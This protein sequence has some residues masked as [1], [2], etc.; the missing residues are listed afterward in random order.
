[1]D[2]GLVH[3]LALKIIIILIVQLSYFPR[4]AIATELPNIRQVSNLS[5]GLDKALGSKVI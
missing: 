2:F 1:M 3:Y 4:V 5:R